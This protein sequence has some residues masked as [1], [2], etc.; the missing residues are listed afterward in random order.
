MAIRAPDGANKEGIIQNEVSLGGSPTINV[1]LVVGKY[2]YSIQ[3]INRPLQFTYAQYKATQ[4][5]IYIIYLI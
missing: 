3:G 5:H 1:T 4:V 2:A